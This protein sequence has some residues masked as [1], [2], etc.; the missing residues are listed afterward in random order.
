MS[1]PLNSITHCKSMTLVTSQGA[2]QAVIIQSYIIYE[3]GGFNL[4]FIICKLSA[5]GLNW[6]ELDVSL[7]LATSVSS[8]HKR[9][10][11]LRSCLEVQVRLLQHDNC[12]LPDGCTVKTSVKNITLFP[13][14]QPSQL[15][16]WRGCQ[17]W[18]QA[19]LLSKGR[20]QGAEEIDNCI[21]ETKIVCIGAERRKMFPSRPEK[22]TKLMNYPFLH[23]R[24]K[25]SSKSEF[26]REDS[27]VV[28]P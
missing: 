20:L 28:Q 1:C 14:P 11:V 26:W 9:K 13:Q 17:C 24:G 19:V 25:W 15:P 21:R 10:L 22:G 16:C 27:F 12:I 5:K 7:R 18:F 4:G 6:V 8:G 3:H 2:I 23:W